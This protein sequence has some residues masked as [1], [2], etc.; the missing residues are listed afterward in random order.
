MMMFKNFN[1]FVLFV[2]NNF[3]KFVLHN[4]ALVC[5]FVKNKTILS[6]NCNYTYFK[7][8]FQFLFARIL[9]LRI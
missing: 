3:N 2:V 6:V 5:N 1:K 9:G 8:S 4:L 7:L